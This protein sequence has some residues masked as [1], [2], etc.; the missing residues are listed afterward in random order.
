MA[1]ENNIVDDFEL[2][3]EIETISLD[4]IDISEIDELGSENDTSITDSGIDSIS[5]DLEQDS[6]FTSSESTP[7]PQTTNIEPQF[8]SSPTPEPVQDTAPLEEISE[9][10]NLGAAETLNIIN[11]TPEPVLVENTEIKP[12]EEIKK[13]V[14]DKTFQKEKALE[15]AY[16][17]DADD[18]I[19]SIDGRELDNV[20]YG[21]E[22]KIGEINLVDDV[23]EESSEIILQETDTPE[24]LLDIDIAVAPTPEISEIDNQTSQTVSGDFSFE[25]VSELSSESLEDDDDEPIALSIEELNDIEVNEEE[26]AAETIITSSNPSIGL[27]SPLNDDNDFSP[28]TPD[29]LAKPQTDTIDLG[30]AIEI[31]E[32]PTDLD[33]SPKSNE[34]TTDVEELYAIYNGENAIPSEGDDELL[35]ASSH[36]IPDFNASAISLDNS[37]NPPVS[38]QADILAEEAELID[39]DEDDLVVPMTD[40]YSDTDSVISE[41]YEEEKESSTPEPEIGSDIHL[42]PVDLEEDLPLEMDELE[43]IS[44]PGPTDT[45]EIEISSEPSLGISTQDTE[46]SEEDTTPIEEEIIISQ[47]DFVE[48]A[49]LDEAE[50][51]SEIRKTEIE[52]IN[53]SEPDINGETAIT[54]EPIDEDETIISSASEMS[55][56]QEPEAVQ[57]EELPISDFEEMPQMEEIVI[58][59]SPEV[60]SLEEDLTFAEMSDTEAMIIASAPDSDD[61]KIDTLPVPDDIE[62]DHVEI[63]EEDIIKPEHS[64]DQDDAINPEM[65]SLNGTEDFSREEKEQIIQNKVESLSLDTKDEMKKVLQYLDNLLEDLPEEKIKEFSQSEYYDLY[66]KIL[67]KL[68]V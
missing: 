54:L 28:S 42:E 60:E 49:S 21:Q 41:S 48:M 3:L 26:E 30:P 65:Y 25:E 62:E 61:N 37:V 24:E 22:D 51:F 1:G 23:P 27:E 59:E 43:E 11:D 68:G 9:D 19:I 7:T 35:E 45:D 36:D 31:P 32:A 66:V 20:I 64:L 17:F 4:D 16:V 55:L 52:D 46:L 50:T 58:H 39:L 14:S 18:E 10:S 47:N 8:T 15:Q 38:D 44:I 5:L 63:L 29:V 53:I 6:S 13:E 57:E 34:K 2:D 12:V 67:D 56:N 33:I 40:D